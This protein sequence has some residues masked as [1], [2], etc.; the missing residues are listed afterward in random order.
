VEIL[1][2]ASCQGIVFVTAEV[3]LE[4]GLEPLTELEVVKVAG[5][6][7]LG[8]IDVSLDAIFVEGSL[9]EL[10]VVNELMLVLGAPLNSSECE[11]ARIERVKYCAV[12]GASCALLDLG[13]LQLKVGIH[14]VEDVYFAYEVGLI[15]HANRLRHILNLC[16]FT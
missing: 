6:N 5:L 3:L 10:V 1:I 15:H 7:E 14:P 11:R 2:F 12:D 16:F 13:E 9:Q 8:N 4:V